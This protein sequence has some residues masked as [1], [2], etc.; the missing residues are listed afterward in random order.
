MQK[1]TARRNRT[2]LQ[3]LRL[4]SQPK[5]LGIGGK[6]HWAA[7]SWRYTSAL[8]ILGA[9]P[10]SFNFSAGGDRSGCHSGVGCILCQTGAGPL[11]YENKCTIWARGVGVA[12]ARHHTRN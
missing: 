10:M 8:A 5:N 7:Q 9:G 4:L 1:K 2:Q 12:G 3:T 11:C 6:A